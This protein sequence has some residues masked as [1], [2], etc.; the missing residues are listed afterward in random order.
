MLTATENW[1]IFE[2]ESASNHNIKKNSHLNRKNEKITCPP[3]FKL[4]SKEQ[5]RAA[6]Y[7]KIYSTISK[8]FQTEG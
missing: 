2:E 7:E 6:F 4:I 1:E 5:K 8:D 3:G